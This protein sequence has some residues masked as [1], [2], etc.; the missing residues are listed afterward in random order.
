MASE[1][2]REF[3]TN[4]SNTIM[5]DPLHYIHCLFGDV[6]THLCPKFNRGWSKAMLKLV[7]ISVIISHCI[8]WM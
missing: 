3:D 8:T 5:I 2:P 6:I 7:H 1:H 4:I